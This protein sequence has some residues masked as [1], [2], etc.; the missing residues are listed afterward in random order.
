MKGFQKSYLRGLGQSLRPTVNVGK[1]EL[2]EGFF[3]EFNRA[4]DQQELVK[5]RFAACKDRKKELAR[6]IA[7][8]SGSE[9]AGIV[10]HTALFFRQHNDPE[11]REI[12]LPEHQDRE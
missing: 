2:D 9:L 1:K 12:R 3:T 4:L 7:A 10:G 8:K 11:K 5:V 6:Q